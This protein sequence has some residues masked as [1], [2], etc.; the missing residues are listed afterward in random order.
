[1]LGTEAPIMARTKAQAK[2][3]AAETKSVP[4][5]T[6]INLKGTEAQ[7]A[8]LEGVH[9][10]TH[11]AKAVIVRLALAAWAEQQGHDPFPSSADDQ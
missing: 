9:R 3:T 1:M 10:K 4:R 11:I 5:N 8:W 7:A 2:T 6:I